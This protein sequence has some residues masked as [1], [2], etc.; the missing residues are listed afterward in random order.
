MLKKHNL[1]LYG[2]QES[3]HIF[4]NQKRHLVPT[5]LQL[6]EMELPLLISGEKSSL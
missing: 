2:S 4:K 3:K 6:S 5:S 1:K